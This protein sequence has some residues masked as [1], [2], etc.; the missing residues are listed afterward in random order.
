MAGQSRYIFNGNLEWAKPSLRSKARFYGNYVS[1]RLTDVGA[2]GLPDIYQEAN[3]VLDFVYE[4]SLSESGKWTMRFNAENLT[5]NYY[6][7]TQGSQ[8]FRNY[9]VGRTFTIGTSYTF[10]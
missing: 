8:P 7:F 4:Y 10:F 1:R 5:D 9:R 3:A 2:L 6:N